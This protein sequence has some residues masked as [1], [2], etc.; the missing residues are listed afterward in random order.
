MERRKRVSG[1]VASRRSFGRRRAVGLGVVLAALFSFIPHAVQACELRAGWAVFEPFQVPNG[2]APPAGLDM[3]I[4]RRVVADAG[5]AIIEYRET[6]W[7]RLL[8]EIKSGRID[9][10]T[11]SSF[12]KARAEYGRYSIPFRSVTYAAVYHNDAP[13]P[14]D[15]IGLEAAFAGDP[16]IGVIR[17]AYIPPAIRKV[18][19]DA[20]SRGRLYEGIDYDTILVLLEKERLDMIVA[21]VIDPRSAFRH[22]ADNRA[23]QALEIDGNTDDIHLLFSRKTVGS[24]VVERINAAIAAFRKTDAYGALFKR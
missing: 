23:F 1:A 9:V 24:D 4:L 20:K 5:C 22:I 16:M 13:K 8:P 21:E 19:D 14:G 17:G 12:T 18:L 2:N 11:S 6:P 3:D 7:P 10:I 15:R